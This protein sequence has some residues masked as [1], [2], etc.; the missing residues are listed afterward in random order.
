MVGILNERG[1]PE[2][3]IELEGLWN[4]LARTRRFS[5]LCGYRMDIFDREA[6]IGALPH[7]CRAHSHVKPAVNNAR[8]ARAVDAALEEVLGAS[9]AGKVYVVIGSQIRENRVPIAQLALMWVSENMPSLA[10]RVLASARSH[11]AS[12]AA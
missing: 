6:Q 10:G 8:L 5:L 9:E 7:V 11:Y 4:K 3:A 12:S 2:A 1:R